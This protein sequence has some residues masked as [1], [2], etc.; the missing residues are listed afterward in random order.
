MS[1]TLETPIA[2][3]YVPVEYTEVGT[4]LRVVVRGEPKGARVRKTP[5]LQR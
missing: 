2:L 4:E 5:F 1:P 3:G